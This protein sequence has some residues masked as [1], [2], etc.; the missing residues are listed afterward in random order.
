MR[1]AGTIRCSKT[2][3]YDL[4]SWRVQPLPRPCAFQAFT[5]G[6]RLNTDDGRPCQEVVYVPV[7][8]LLLTVVARQAC[9]QAPAAQRTA[10]IHVVTPWE[11]A[12]PQATDS[13]WHIPLELQE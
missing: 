13:D 11:T 2:R 6:I 1:R 12:G 4:R 9:R 3:G 7:Q 10:H 5:R 8:P